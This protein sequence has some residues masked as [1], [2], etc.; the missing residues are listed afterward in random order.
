MTEVKLRLTTVAPMLLNGAERPE[1]RAPSVRGVLRYWARAIIGASTN[2]T[3]AVWDRESEIFGSTGMGSKVTIRVIPLRRETDTVSLLPHRDSRR[4]RASAIA[5]EQKFTIACSTPP[6][7]PFPSLFKQTLAVWLLLG[8][9]GKRSRRMFG[10][11]YLRNVQGDGDANLERL[12]AA[13]IWEEWVDTAKEILH[14]IESTR[15]IPSPSFPTLHPNHSWVMIGHR[16]YRDAEEANVELFH[17]LLRHADYRNHGEKLFGRAM[18]GRQASPL[19]AQVRRIGDELYPVLTY[20]RTSRYPKSRDIATLNEF[21][22]DAK[23]L[24]DA[25]VIWGSTFA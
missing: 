17:R 24:L 1:L 5:E 12:A 19:I 10:G 2:D 21:F 4:G 18:G 16:P 15:N 23:R 13:D 25:E 20:M 9:L 11:V 22:D 6:G 3:R 8:G 14:G 7:V